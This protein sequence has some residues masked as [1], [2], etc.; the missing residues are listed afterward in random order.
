[1]LALAT[2]VYDTYGGLVGQ[3]AEKQ[4]DVRAELDELGAEFE[5]YYDEC[6][7]VARSRTGATVRRERRKAAR[8]V[9][10]ELTAA[11][12]PADRSPLK[13]VRRRVGSIVRR[14]GEA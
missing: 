5:A 6:F 4:Q 12:Q 8:R 2:R 14:S 11:Q 9:R 10:E 7:D 13:A 1:V 3:P